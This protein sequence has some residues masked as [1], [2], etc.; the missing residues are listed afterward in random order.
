MAAIIS[1]D[2]QTGRPRLET[3]RVGT[4]FFTVLLIFL[5]FSSCV[6]DPGSGAFLTPGS[7]IRCLFDPWI[8]DSVAF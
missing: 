2:I 8:R 6:A 7:G 5:L 1:L 3:K 4:F